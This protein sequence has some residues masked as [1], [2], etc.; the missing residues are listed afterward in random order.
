MKVASWISVSPIPASMARLSWK[1]RLGVGRR[2]AD[3]S[4]SGSS[5]RRPSSLRRRPVTHPQRPVSRARK[6]FCHAE[7][8]VR[9]IAMVSPT[10][11]ICTPSVSST[12]ENFSKAKRGIFTTT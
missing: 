8:N 11:F 12:S 4:V 9:P 5:S 2:S 10:D 7:R 6:P 3:R 1:G